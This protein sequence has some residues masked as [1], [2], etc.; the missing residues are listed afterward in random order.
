[1]AEDLIVRAASEEDL[2]AIAGIQAAAP[3]SSQWDPR[4]YL[5][6]DCRIAVHRDSIVGFIVTRPLAEGEWEILNLAV[7]PD[8]RRQGV[9]RQLLSDVLAGRRG[10]FYL[11]VRES[12]AAARRFYEHA[13]FGMVTERLQYYSNPEESAIVMKLYSC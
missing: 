3:E 10:D 13:G 2:P 6:F 7:A 5:S 4:D 12:N 8:S 11:E 9:G 1:M